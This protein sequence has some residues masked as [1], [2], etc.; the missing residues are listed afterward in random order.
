M[1]TAT[2]TDLPL[3]ADKPRSSGA[4]FFRR[5]IDGIIVA[6]QR[7]A[8]AEIARM[9]Q[10]NGGTMTDNAEREIGRRLGAGL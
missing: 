7:Q 5:L 3:Q 9:L 6:R 1:K 10:L 4:G 8:D 2:Y